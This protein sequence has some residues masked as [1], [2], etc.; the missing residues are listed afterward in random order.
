MVL[1]TWLLA[2]NSKMR[3]MFIHNI[4]CLGANLNSNNENIYLF[5]T[6]Y[7]INMNMSSYASLSIFYLYYE[8]NPT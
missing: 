6:D 2:D 7:G 4:H 8:T 1:I 5:S 3:A